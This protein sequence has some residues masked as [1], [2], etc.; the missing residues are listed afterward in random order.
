MNAVQIFIT[1]I[2]VIAIA[3]P[4]VVFL[5]TRQ[6]AQVDKHKYQNWR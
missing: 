5:Y 2:A 4:I 1:V 6:I 3:G